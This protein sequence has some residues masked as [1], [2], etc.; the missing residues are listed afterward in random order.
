MERQFEIQ[1]R[2]LRNRIIKMSSLV[3]EQLELAIKSIDKNDVAIAEIVKEREKKVNKL[4]RKIEVTCQKIIALSQPVAL[5]LRLVISALT[6]NTNLE[7]I[8]D[9]AEHIATSH[10]VELKNHKLL[11]KTKY[12]EMTVLVK[13]MLKHSIDS[14]NNEDAELAKKVIEM[15]DQL[16][17]L[18]AENRKVVISAMK[19]NPTIIDEALAIL[20]VTRHIE[21]IGDHATNI[22]EDVYF[23]VEAQLIKHKYAK[24]I[25][26]DMDSEE[27]DDE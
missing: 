3:E 11:E 22:A 20:E 14:F 18:F 27:D 21:R 16:D 5:D 26:S 25:F 8:G 6:I 13:E 9:L 23:I 24:Y 17:K 12:A 15:D 2:K 10:L 1:L 19:Q 7:R 4:D